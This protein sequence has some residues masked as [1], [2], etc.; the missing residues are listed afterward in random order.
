MW[1]F[2]VVLAIPFS[3]ELSDRLPSNQTAAIVVT[4]WVFAPLVVPLALLYGIVVFV[5][6]LACGYIE[7]YRSWFPRSVK[8]PNAKVVDRE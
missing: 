7:L 6:Y 3:M 8:L 5:I 1:V 4:L 2:G